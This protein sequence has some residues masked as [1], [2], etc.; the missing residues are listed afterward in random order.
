MMAGTFTI[1]EDDAE[2]E[3]VRSTTPGGTLSPAMVALIAGK[4]LHFRTMEGIYDLSGT[5]GE[6]LRKR[7]LK[8][9]TLADGE[10]GYYAWAEKIEEVS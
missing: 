9:G 3:R 7:G 1:V 8:G 6:T 4:T 2:A 5:G 10:G